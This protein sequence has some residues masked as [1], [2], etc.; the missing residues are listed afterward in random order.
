MEC[1]Y[2]TNWYQS[3]CA[4]IKHALVQYRYID[5]DSNSSYIQNTILQVQHEYP[6]LHNS[7]IQTDLWLFQLNPYLHKYNSHKFVIKENI[8]PY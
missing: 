1:L 5:L 7:F 8:H 6:Y 3:I 4:C 2:W